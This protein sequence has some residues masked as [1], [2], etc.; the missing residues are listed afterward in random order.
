M[1]LLKLIMFQYTLRLC[2]E[3]SL[4]R[5]SV[6]LHSIL[7][8]LDEATEI[9]L[10]V[11]QNYFWKRLKTLVTWILFFRWTWIVLN[12]FSILPK[13]TRKDNEKSGN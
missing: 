12:L 13:E 10:Q 3:K 1:I 5:E 9:A 11:L 7:G 8:Q 6:L 2:E 4:K